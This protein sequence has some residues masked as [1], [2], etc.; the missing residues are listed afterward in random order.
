MLNDI[1]LLTEGKKPAFFLTTG[2]SQNFGLELIESIL[3]E[4]ADIIIN[5]A[6]LLSLCRSCLI[7]LVVRLISERG[8]FPT[9]V[10]AMRLVPLFL[11][12]LLSALEPEC[13]TMLSLLNHV[14][15]P[16]NAV[17][18]KRALCL[19]LYRGIYNNSALVRSL[20]SRFDE[21][22]GKR[23]IIR[24]HLALLVRLAS[25][26][27][28][29]IGLGQKSSPSSHSR[30]SSV[31][32]ATVQADSLIG[33]IG[34]TVT[35]AEPDAPGISTRWS[36]LRIPCIEQL[37]KSEAPQLPA[38]YI[39][40]LAL[41]CIITFSEGLAKFLLPFTLPPEVKGKRKARSNGNDTQNDGSSREV[42]PEENSRKQQL[43]RNQSLQNHTLSVNPLHLK[44]HELYNEICTSSD[45]VENCWPALLATYST[46]LNAT[47][48]SE[49]Y[50]ALIRSFQRF[51]QVA[52]LLDLSTPRD[53][54]LTAL[55]KQSVPPASLNTLTTG[56]TKAS[57]TIGG[58]ERVLQAVHNTEKE[59]DAHPS[60]S[61]T[62]GR[63]RQP[64]DSG[65]YSLSTRNL[66][67]LR[68][69]LNL[70]I[71]LGPVLQKS[72][73]IILETLQHT[74]SILSYAE[75]TRRQSSGHLQQIPSSGPAADD[76]SDASEIALEIAAA[77]TAA[78]RM[79]DSTSELPDPAFMD[80]LRCLFSLFRNLQIDS[81]ESPEFLDGNLL[82]PHI[83]ARKHY[84]VPSLSQISSDGASVMRGNMFVL[85][86]LGDIIS[87]NISRLQRNEAQ[88][89][90]W[91]LTT[92]ALIKSLSFKGSSTEFRVEAARKLNNL[93]LAVITTRDHRLPK[94]RDEI[95]SRCLAAL[96]KE[97]SSLYQEDRPGSKIA[98]GCDF[99]IHRL[100]LETLRLILEHCG[101]S[102]VLGWDTVFAVITSIFVKSVSGGHISHD[103]DEEEEEEEGGENLS[104]R[105]PKLLL[106]SF[107]PLQLICS[108]FLSSVPQPCLIILVDTLYTFSCQ[109][110]DLNVSLTVSPSIFFDKVSR[111]C[112]QT[113]TFFR[114]VSDFLLLERDKLDFEA[115]ITRSKS[116]KDLIR[117]IQEGHRSVSV[118]ALWL[119][120]LLRLVRLVNNGNIE[121]RHSEYL[122]FHIRA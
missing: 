49:Y 108:D 95:R 120:L 12:N 65:P 77:K 71:A 8:I 61:L 87:C 48:D 42:G 29:V 94:E 106:S 58:P 83:T 90:G 14:L 101:D 76:N 25:E 41:T 24:D 105:S 107:A 22:D 27:P 85:N 33:S 30:D 67:C 63:Q 17:V 114:N 70:G 38:A 1:C 15:D 86:T 110:Q 109:E 35:M 68:A 10:R 20:Y 51:T 84:K 88:G 111:L 3:T 11:G 104:P 98:E 60:P 102:L 36:T 6:E 46:F 50:H 116:E 89:T 9:T 69:L 115:C 16:D 39:Y 54:F 7:P 45:M 78:G 62:S 13:E 73:L 66:L 37:D 72:W 40:S 28:A 100:S 82:S 57:P 4:Y 79:L 43:S 121:V 21:R 31:E 2:L 55:A 53:A 118:T 19:E 119:C 92:E 26:K 75:T 103:D 47:L 52:G 18:W 64:T 56:A 117:I 44:G 99:E 32:Q 23:N 112:R 5:H 122:I 93:I 113:I 91:D 74:D 80:I 59:R 34:A 81:T 97:I 96:L